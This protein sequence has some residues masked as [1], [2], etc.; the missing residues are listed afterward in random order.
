MSKGNIFVF[1]NVLRESHHAMIV[2][3][4]E[5]NGRP[6]IASSFFVRF[7]TGF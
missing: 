7:I 2:E 6:Q 1:G 4:G 5:A 3:I